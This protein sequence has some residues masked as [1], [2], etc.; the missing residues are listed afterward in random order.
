MSLIDRL[1]AGDKKATVTFYK[2]YSPSIFEYLRKKLPRQEDA[3]EMMHDVFLEALD[4]LPLLRNK[5]SISSWLYTIA[6][7]EVVDFY[8]KQKIKSILLSQI[9]FLQLVAN[10]VSQPEFEYEK[11]RVRERIEKAFSLLSL[12]HQKI[13]RLHYEDG[14]AIKKLAL[15]FNLSFKA[16][17][18]L[19]FRAR[20]NFI[21]AY[22]RA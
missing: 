13:L 9:P 1:L 5:D 15:L 6:R 17:E 20:Q 2:K 12:K 8:R 14:I 10:E 18:S 16:T 21:R 3:Q 4:A 19:L 22:E 7:N 11:D